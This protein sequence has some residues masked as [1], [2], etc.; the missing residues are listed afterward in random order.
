MKANSEAVF[1]LLKTARGQIDGII[2]M[3]DEDQ[4]CIDIVNQ[5]MACDAILRKTMK[6][7]LHDHISGCV[8][9]AFAG[10]NNEAE[11][12]K[13]IDEIISIITKLG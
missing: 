12:E 2:K 11:Q 9:D 4:Y 10:G 7:V 6:N 3:V 8:R 5:I 1:R 13:K